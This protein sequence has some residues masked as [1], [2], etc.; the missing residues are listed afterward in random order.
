M[1]VKGSRHTGPG[2]RM[3][4]RGKAWRLD[5]VLVG[6]SKMSS[7]QDLKSETVYIYFPQAY[8]MHSSLCEG[9]FSSCPLSLFTLRHFSVLPALFQPLSLIGR[10]L[11]FERA[12]TS[13]NRQ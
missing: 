8:Y 4:D 13:Y 5:V 9:A 7:N 11:C 1:R 3:S 6:W 10:C 2:Y 12:C